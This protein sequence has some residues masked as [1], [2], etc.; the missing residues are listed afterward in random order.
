MG[1]F[2]KNQFAK[3][4]FALAQAIAENDQCYSLVGGGDSVSAINK[5]GL[6]DKISHISTLEV[7]PL[8]S[9]S[10]KAACLELAP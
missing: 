7:E 4:T 5:S 9:L 6:A 3:G 10:K 8:L 1:M 2:E